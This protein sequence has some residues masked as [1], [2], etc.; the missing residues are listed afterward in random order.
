MAC[1]ISKNMFELLQ[2]RLPIEIQRKI[3]ED[4]VGIEC[5]EHWP[6]V[7][8]ELGRRNFGQLQQHAVFAAT[9]TTASQLMKFNEYLEDNNIADYY[10]QQF[11]LLDTDKPTFTPYIRYFELLDVVQKNPR[12]L[13]FVVPADVQR[14]EWGEMWLARL[15]GLMIPT[16][17]RITDFGLREDPRNVPVYRCGLYGCGAVQQAVE[18]DPAKILQFLDPLAAQ[19][20]REFWRSPGLAAEYWANHYAAQSDSGED[21]DSDED[22]DSGDDG[23]GEGDAALGY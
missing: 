3:L 5:R 6:S 2:G 8:A 17:I 12:G 11:N 9:F 1:T 22:C 10:T 20:V 15:K 23:E 4:K 7:M 19:A 16:G 14:A 18:H 13:P 21:C